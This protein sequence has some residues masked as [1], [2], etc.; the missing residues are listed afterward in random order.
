MSKPIKSFFMFDEE[1]L[2]EIAKLVDY[3]IIK[4]REL[5]D[6]KHENMFKEIREIF[7]KYG[8]DWIENKNQRMKKS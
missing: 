5:D 7:I 2:D 8:Y 6:S 3:S 1:M 4:A